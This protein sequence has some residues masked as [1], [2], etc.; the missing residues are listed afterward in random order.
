MSVV[1]FAHSYR[2]RD[3]RIT[4]FFARLIRS[5]G[6]TLS[7]DPPSEGVNAA[8]LQR[9]LNASEGMVAVLSRRDGGTSPHILFEINLAIKTGAPLLVFIEDTI[10]NSVI[11]RHVMQQRF[12]FRWYLRE[13]GQHRYMLQSFK[14]YLNEYSPPR[15]RPQSSRRVCVLTGLEKLDSSIRPGFLRW[16]EETAEYETLQLPEASDP[17]ASYETLR[18]SNLAIAFQATPPGYADGLLAGIAIPTISLTQDQTMQFPPWPP[19]EYQPLVLPDTDDM[20]PTVAKE[21]NLFEEDFLDLPDQGAV[22]R[23][24]ALLVDLQG[25]YN[26]VTRNQVQEV[27]MGDK[28][29]TTGQ[30]AA[31]GPNAHVHDVAFQAWQTFST[32]AGQGG[33]LTVL[34]AQLDELRQHLRSSANTRD[35]DATVAEIGAAASAAEE[36][37]GPR[38]LS[39]LARVG[40]WALAAATTIGTTVAA[41]AIKA[42]TG[43]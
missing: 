35:E 36:G 27:V 16:V 13:V 25:D 19:R 34:A 38:A 7:L 10:G 40:K 37:D 28:Y 14:R 17:Y 6:L 8:K 23:Y 24:A 42:A 31:V 20:I 5:E 30:V 39:H 43:I 41:A 2:D 32:G 18:N 1:Y 26:Q 11:S 9:H 15:F 3:A 33:D 4:D 29:V 22:D 21:I 12:S